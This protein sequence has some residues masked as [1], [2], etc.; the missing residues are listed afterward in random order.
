VGSPV[1]TTRNEIAHVAPGAR[2]IPWTTAVCPPPAIRTVVPAGQ[3]VWTRGEAAMTGVSR[4]NAVRRVGTADGFWPIRFPGQ[5]YDVETEAVLASGGR[6]VKRPGLTQNRYR[7]YDALVGA[8]MS[9]DPELTR[10]LSPYAYARSCPTLYVDPSGRMS[11][12]KSDIVGLVTTGTLGAA[13]IIG[14]AL[15]APTGGAS[16]YVMGAL[17]GGGTGFGMGAFGGAAVDDCQTKLGPAINTVVKNA[18]NAQR[19]KEL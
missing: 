19:K 7:T 14:V 8:Y 6:V 9:V 12:C 5:Y 3:V 18:K 15:A 17:V 4:V 10:T 1:P 2:S 11:E 16:V 13:S